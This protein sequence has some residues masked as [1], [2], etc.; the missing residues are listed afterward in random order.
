MKVTT[1]ACLFGAWCA[2]EIQKSLVQLIKRDV[3]GP[4]VQKKLTLLDIGTGTGLL[5]LMIAQKNKILIDAVEIEKEAAEQ[6]EKNAAASPWVNQL[7]VFHQDIISFK[8]D[9][10]DFIVSN[11]PFYENE[12]ASPQQKKNIA[13]HSHLLTTAQL[14]EQIKY[15]LA[16]NGIFFLFVG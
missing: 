7:E 8:N 2:R 3:P 1:D 14:T 4:G 12:L 13:H 10:Y 6:A 11:P 15:K 5:S 16:P 9:Q